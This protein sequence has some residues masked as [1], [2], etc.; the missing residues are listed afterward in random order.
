MA[1]AMTRVNRIPAS[2]EDDFSLGLLERR[3][4]R[5]DP[6]LPPL[7][8]LHGAT[9]GACVFDLPIPGYSLMSAL[10]SE[11]RCVYAI[12]IRGYG[13]SRP[14]T[15]IDA[16]L[17]GH[18]PF[19]RAAEAV[20]DI[21]AAVS[22]ICSRERTDAVD[23]LGFSWGAVNGACYAALHPEQIARLAL[24][25]PL[26][27]EVNAAWLDRISDPADRA[28]LRADIGVY[29]FI[30]LPDLLQRW[31]TE[32]VASDKGRYREPGV[33][34]A[35]FDEM[36]SQDA[37]TRSDGR[38]AYRCPSGAF[39]DLVDIFNG[40]PLYDAA[41]LTMPTLLIRGSDDTTST[42]TDARRLFEA[43]PSPGKRYIVVTPGSHFLLLERNRTQLHRHLNDFLQPMKTR[44]P[45]STEGLL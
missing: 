4:E 23:L 16:A 36:A 20:A 27:A 6:R 31:D 40:R 10:A 12:D 33:A 39:A 17:D 13:A 19:P 14:G 21:G 24:Y 44:R 3:P 35:V 30:T 45:P 15:V 7:L 42:D 8:L 41:N 9:L 25:A 32:I 11:G 37:H 26:Y 38:P 5:A 18:R 28:R 29:R 1:T 34:E 2:G 43:I 22:A